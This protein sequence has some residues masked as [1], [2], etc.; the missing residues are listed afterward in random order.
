[1]NFGRL[2]ASF[3]VSAVLGA[4]ANA[5]VLYDATL[6]SIDTK[7][8]VLTV[9]D[10][11]Q[12][13]SFSYR[14][15]IEVSLEWTRATIAQLQPGMPATV[16]SQEPGVANRLEAKA[17]PEKSGDL[18]VNVNTASLKQLQALPRVGP[19]LASAIV[20]ERQVRPF[21]RPTELLRVPGIKEA[22]L[23][24]LLPHITTD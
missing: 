11:G 14:D 10:R 22:T 4:S 8:R 19:V 15:T 23:Q 2:L 18:L 3:L 1:M 12:T 7:G 6:V 5:E 17:A 16:Y 24:L 9:R 13:R 21:S 20:K